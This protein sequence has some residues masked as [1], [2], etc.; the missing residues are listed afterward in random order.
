ML[1]HE[2]AKDKDDDSGWADSFDEQDTGVP[3]YRDETLP[4][5]A[6]TGDY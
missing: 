4:P 1:L 5:W 3:E 2:P 6:P